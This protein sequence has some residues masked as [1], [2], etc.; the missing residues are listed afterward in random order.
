LLDLVHS[1]LYAKSSDVEL[2]KNEP[3]YIH[4]RYL[5][6]IK[7][8]LVAPF[9]WTRQRAA[10]FLR[11]SKRHFQRLVRAYRIFGIPGLRFKPK[12]PNK[13]PNKSPMWIEKT[14]I[15]MK[16][17]TG[18]GKT[19]ISALVNEQFRIKSWDK[20]IGPS[21]AYNICLRNNL[22]KPPAIDPQT[23]KHF[24]WKHPNNLIQSDLTQFNGI[25]ILTM[26]DDH[27]RF[28]WSDIIEN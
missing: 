27:T 3:D 5:T 13:I 7:S 12:R 8:I 4:I 11:I 24:D 22:Q 2:L 20:R 17:L 15:K 21:L 23:L 16:K 14:V 6:I 19:S 26:E 10:N 1:K 9:R 28:A 18:F 25:P